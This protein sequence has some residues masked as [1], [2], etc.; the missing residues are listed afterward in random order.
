VCVNLFCASVFV[1][2][3]DLNLSMGTGGEG[4]GMGDGGVCIPCPAI[5]A[6]PKWCERGVFEAPAAPATC[7]CSPFILSGG[8]SV[9]IIMEAPES[10]NQNKNT[11]TKI[12]L[13]ISKANRTD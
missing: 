4:V 8:V 13:F 2:R 9:P 3:T 1:L 12:N 7:G 10:A 5:A 6:R 11:P